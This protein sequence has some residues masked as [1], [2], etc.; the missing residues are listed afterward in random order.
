[1]RSSFIRVLGFLLILSGGCS[2]NPE[3][4]P[5]PEPENNPPVISSITITPSRIHR[6]EQGNLVGVA[7]DED[8]DFLLYRWSASYGIF[9][10]RRDIPIVTYRAP[11]NVSADTVSFFVSDIR[12]STVRVQVI[13]LV[14]IAPPQ[15]LKASAGTRFVEVTWDPSIDNRLYDFLGYEIYVSERSF[16]SMPQEDWEAFKIP[17]DPITD[18]KYVVRNLEQGTIYYFQVRSLRA[19]GERSYFNGEKD[20]S[21]LPQGLGSI[22][23]EINYPQP[24]AQGFDFSEGVMRTFR[25][26]DPSIRDGIDLY[27]GTADPEDGPGPLMF[28]SPERL[29]YRHPDWAG[30]RV[31]L[32]PIG[33]NWFV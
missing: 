32:K 3:R 18:N 14:N 28:K 5:Q 6:G 8:F 15:N 13:R 22:L 20:T 29:A 27:I 2:L 30:R 4:N 21:P 33:D 1:M 16:N 26:D 24:Y 11:D 10:F 7:S 25:P 23:R 17:T 9:P 19:T 12:D 31:Q